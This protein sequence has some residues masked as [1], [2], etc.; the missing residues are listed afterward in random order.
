VRYVALNQLKKVVDIDYN[1]VQRHKNTIM[2]CLKDHDIQIKKQALDLLY[3][4]TNNTNVKSIVKELVNYLL[5][6]EPEFKKE[7]ANK[8]CQICE[9]YAPNKKWHIDTVVKVLTLSEGYCREEYI[10]QIITVIAT[11]PELHQ[12]SVTKVYFAL[13]ENLNQIGLVQLGVWLV[14]EFGEMLVNGSCKNP[15]GN[16][17][18]VPDHEIMDLMT[19]ILNDHDKKGDRS[20]I[21]IMW[22]LTSISKLS[23]RIGQANPVDPRNALSEISKQINANLKKFE[24]HMNIEIQQRACEF[25]HVL[26]SGFDAERATI[27]EPM[28][29][30]GDEN[31]LV[32]A[33]NRKTLDDD[34]NGD[35]LLMGIG[36]GSSSTP[37]MTSGDVGGLL[38][39]DLMLGGPTTTEQQPVVGGN[40]L[41]DMMDLFGAPS[42]SQPAQTNDFMGMGAPVQPSNDLNDIFGGGMVSQPVAQQPVADLFGGGNDLFSMGASQPAVDLFGGALSAFPSYLAYEDTILAIGLDC[43]R[44]GGNNHLITA[45]FKNK[46]GIQLS[47]INLQMA[48]Q[49]Y[50]TLKMKPANGS[51]LAPN[52]TDLTQSMSVTNS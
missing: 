7:L 39:L 19:K 44:E 14:G 10:S 50:M 12:Y 32:D 3:K 31:M 43:K 41:G 48:A 11:T 30:K 36:G 21:V 27:F 40:M 29:F 5:T 9:K 18:I 26:G 2:E 15:D 45:H 24:T 37:G 23:I 22:T 51:C 17:I 42:Q 6:S 13:K 8:I 25:Q 16:P 33:K 28:P 49:K 20:D 38:D 1:A 46:G 35:N 4:I 34:D 47:N 52:A